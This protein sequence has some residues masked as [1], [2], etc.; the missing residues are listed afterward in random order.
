VGMIDYSRACEILSGKGG[1]GVNV[2]TPIPGAR[3]LLLLYDVN[4]IGE[5][6]CYLTTSDT[7]DCSIA[8]ICRR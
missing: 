6:Q 3:L 8:S 1:G 5:E 4:A 2:R 7:P